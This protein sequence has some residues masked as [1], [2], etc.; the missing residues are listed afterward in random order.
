MSVIEHIPCT[1]YLQGMC[2][3]CP[4]SSGVDRVLVAVLVLLLEWV[5]VHSSVSRTVAVEQERVGPTGGLA[6]QLATEGLCVRFR[7]SEY[8]L[9]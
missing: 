2:F 5:V 1:Y 4:Y 8:R 6:L 7:S 3:R 9:V